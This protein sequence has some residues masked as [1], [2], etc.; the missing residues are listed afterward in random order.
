MRIKLARFAAAALVMGV[1]TGAMAQYVCPPGYAYYGGA[2]QPVAPSY[3]NPVS[4]A[5][6]GE[7]AGAA[8]GNRIVF[9]AGMRQIGRLERPVAVDRDAMHYPPLTLVVVERIV[10]HAAIV[11]KRDRTLFPA[12]AAGKF[13]PDRVLP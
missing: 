1:S 4:G 10:L 6:S 13:R 12:E 9:V 7:A 8:A 3:S 5:V 11:P 2:C